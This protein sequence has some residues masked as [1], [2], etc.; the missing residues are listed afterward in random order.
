MSTPA[1]IDWLANCH[2]SAKLLG[3]ISDYKRR[4]IET[5]RGRNIAICVQGQLRTFLT[6]EVYGSFVE[7]LEFLRA[8]ADRVVVFWY[9]NR[10]SSYRN[11]QN[12]LIDEHGWNYQRMV[13]VGISRDAASARDL[14][15]RKFKELDLL[16]L[17]I[18]SRLEEL[19]VEYRLAYYDDTLWNHLMGLLTKKNSIWNHVMGLLTKKNSIMTT[20]M[21]QLYLMKTCAGLLRQYEAA[22]DVLFH[23]VIRTRPDVRY[24]SGRMLATFSSFDLDDQ[25]CFQW[26]HAYCFPR[27]IYDYVID[28]FDIE[29]PLFDIRGLKD[30]KAAGLR[31][32]TDHTTETL[33]MYIRDNLIPVFLRVNGFNRFA[34]MD[35]AELANITP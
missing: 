15:D 24:H 7:L 23:N 33:L 9:V 11:N 22:H 18:E 21:F 29:D 6:P 1:V 20:Y 10:K 35:F 17:S 3:G 12:D 8:R 31:P 34:H 28:A 4:R 13:R 27:Y 14:A 25:L 2:A 26:D 19:D 32:D 16:N 5:A 30:I